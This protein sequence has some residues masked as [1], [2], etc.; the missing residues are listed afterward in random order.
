MAAARIPADHATLRQSTLRQSKMRQSLT[1]KPIRSTRNLRL[2][3]S[4][5]KQPNSVCPAA[6]NPDPV[7]PRFLPSC[8][9]FPL[10][11]ALKQQRPENSR[12]QAAA[13]D[14]LK[15]D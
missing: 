10:F 5:A 3:S 7:A 1:K 2:C 4:D 14:L 6:S 9:L 13:G 12:S 8:S 11:P 15:L